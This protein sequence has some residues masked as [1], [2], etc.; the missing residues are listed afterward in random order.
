M[1]TESAENKPS[2]HLSDITFRGLGQ[3]VKSINRMIPELLVGDS[4]QLGRMICCMAAC[5]KL[6]TNP[7]N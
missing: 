3:I 1:D 4:D 7:G 6:K 2:V 5:D